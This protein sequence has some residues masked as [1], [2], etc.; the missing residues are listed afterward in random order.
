[1]LRVSKD[2]VERPGG[3][4]DAG[5]QVAYAMCRYGNGVGVVAW[6]GVGRASQLRVIKVAVLTGIRC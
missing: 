6:G 4:V 5:V 2:G 1:M 3:V